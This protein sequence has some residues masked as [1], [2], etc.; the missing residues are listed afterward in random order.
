M[1]VREAAIQDVPALVEIRA[2]YYE[3]RNTPVQLRNDVSWWVADDGGRV[4]AVQGYRDATGQR[5][6]TDTYA[7][8]SNRGKLGLLHLLTEC[9][10]RADSEGV[11]LVGMTEPDN[12]KN[13]RAMEKRGYKLVAYLY[14]RQPEAN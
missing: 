11:L 12:V 1:T 8:D 3:S 14:A 7:E 9:H 4:V 6:I 10:K 13:Q 5:E 2:A